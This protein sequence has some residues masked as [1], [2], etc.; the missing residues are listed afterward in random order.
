LRARARGDSHKIPRSQGNTLCH[1]PVPVPGI[2]A[3]ASPLISAP[4]EVAR[5]A[6]RAAQQSRHRKE[7]AGSVPAHE[8][9]FAEAPIDIVLVRS[10]DD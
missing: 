3:P 1:N 6:E 7:Y 9:P 2:D 5:A 4:N 8:L 10:G